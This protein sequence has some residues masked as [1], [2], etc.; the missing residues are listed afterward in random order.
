MKINCLSQTISMVEPLFEHHFDLYF[1]YNS[2]K[3]KLLTTPLI[4]IL[5]S[6]IRNR[7]QLKKSFFCFMEVHNICYRDIY[8]VKILNVICNSLYKIPTFFLFLVVTVS[9][10]LCFVFITHIYYLFLGKY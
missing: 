7:I 5:N 1:I 4:V 6:T 2:P 9:C 8:T 10:I 3:I